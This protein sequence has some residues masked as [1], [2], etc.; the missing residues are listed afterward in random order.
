MLT[1]TTPVSIPNLQKIHV[2]AV[3]LDGNANVATV[4]CSVQGSGGVIYGVVQIQIHDG[5]SQGLRATVSPLGFLDR[6]E[7]FTAAT[8]TGFTDLVTASTGGISARNKAVE[9]YLVTA[10]LLPP[11]AVA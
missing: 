4:T 7:V 9:S 1:L 6:M 11:G 5:T 8:P 10:G 2:D 3:Q